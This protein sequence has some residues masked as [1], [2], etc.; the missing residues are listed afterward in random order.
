MEIIE[1]TNI[2]LISPFPVSEAR[3][4]FGW[5]YAYKSVIETDQSPKSADE[6]AQYFEGISP[7]VLSY[8][9]I[10]KHNTLNIPHEAPLIGMVAFEPS[11][12]WNGYMHVASKR[13]AWA[14]GLVEEG[15]KTAIHDIFTKRPDLTRVSA[16]V[17]PR[18]RMAGNLAKRIGFKVDGFFEDYVTQSGTPQPMIHYGL[19][20]KRW[21][22]LTN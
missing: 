16:M 22:E 20:R 10:D 7:Y 8:G 1:S 12:L 21:E 14:S 6:Y 3:R 19:T 5:M 13:R 18:N 15:A 2:D 11:T 17:L 9:V 4:V